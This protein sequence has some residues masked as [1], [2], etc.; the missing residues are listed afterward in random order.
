MI[1][2]VAQKDQSIEDPSV[3][4]MYS[5]GTVA[6]ILQVLTMPDGNTYYHLIQ[7]KKRFEIEQVLTEE[8]Y[9]KAKIKGVKEENLKTVRVWCH[10]RFH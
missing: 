8:P 6:Q 4:D 1:G 9:I 7:G 3:L 10:S 2:V 5:L